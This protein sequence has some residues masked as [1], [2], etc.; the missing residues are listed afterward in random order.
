MN[1]PKVSLD[2]INLPK[3]IASHLFGEHHG[4]RH[5][6]FVGVIVGYVGVLIAH[7]AHLFPLMIIQ[8]FVDLVGYGIHGIGAAPFIEYGIEKINQKSC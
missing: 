8:L 4:H 2:Q 3:K 5:K 6:M 1:R 7:S